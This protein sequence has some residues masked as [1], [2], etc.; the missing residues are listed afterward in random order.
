VKK[1]ATRTKTAKVTPPAT[2]YTAGR[3]NIAKPVNAKIGR[4][5]KEASRFLLR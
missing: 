5:T 1:P 3:K 4:I 2:A